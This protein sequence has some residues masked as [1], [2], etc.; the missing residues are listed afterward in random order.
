[1]LLPPIVIGEEPQGRLTGLGQPRTVIVAFQPFLVVLL[2]L[3]K[4]T[5]HTFPVE[6]NKFVFV[7]VLLSLVPVT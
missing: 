2:E 4:C 6:A 1:M 5:V 3:L 7:P